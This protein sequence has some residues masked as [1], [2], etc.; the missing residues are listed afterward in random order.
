MTHHTVKSAGIAALVCV[1]VALRLATPLAA[2]PSSS[3]AA[4]GLQRLLDA[5]LARVPGTAGVWVKHLT[6]GEEAAVNADRLTR[7]PDGLTYEQAASFA[8]TYG[9]S[10]V[11]LAPS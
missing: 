1:V 2:Q 3:R 7:L 9:T 11:A 10:H 8:V 6:T 4:S 5:E